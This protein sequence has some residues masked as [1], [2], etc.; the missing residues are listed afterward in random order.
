M[1]SHPRRKFLGVPR[2]HEH[3]PWARKLA[4]Q[5]FSTADT[6]YNASARY[7]LHHIL[8]VPGYEMAIVDDVFL[9]FHKL[10]SLSV[11]RQEVQGEQRWSLRPFGL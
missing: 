8:A 3:R 10:N 2:L 7:A 11:V 9:A 5:A 6:G 4:D 1:C